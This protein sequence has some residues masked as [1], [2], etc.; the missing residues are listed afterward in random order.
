MA[1]ISEI[2]WKENKAVEKQQTINT[3]CNRVD[4]PPLNDG[5]YPSPKVRGGLGL[6]MVRRPAI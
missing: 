6:R 1:K 4:A 3:V 2:E 5:V